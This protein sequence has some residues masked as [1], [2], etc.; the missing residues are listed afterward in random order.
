MISFTIFV[1]DDEQVV[2]EGIS[3]VLRKY[4]HVEAFRSGESAIDSMSS[5]PPDMVLLDVGLPGMSG[6]QA[7]KKIKQR[8]PDM[9]VIMITAFEDVSTVVAAMKLGAYD[10]VVKPVQMD[11]LLVAVRNAFDTVSMRKE[12]Q[13]LHEK[14]LKENLPCFIGE[15]NAIQDVMDI[16]KKAAQSTDT[17]I[18]IQGETGTG[19]ELIAKAIHYRSPHFKGPMIA[20]NC[21]SIPKELIESEL[22]GYEKGAFSGAT[23][24]GKAG[25]VEAADKGTLFL[26]EIGDMSLEAQAKLLRFLEDGEF[27]KVGGTRKRKIS[28]RVVSATNK[29]LLQMIQE[30]RFR[31]DLYHRIS[32]VKIVVPSLNQRRDDI[33]PIAKHFLV[34][35]SQNLNK[36]FTGIAPQAESILKAFEWKGNVRELKNVI[37]KGVLL[38]DGPELILQHLELEMLRQHEDFIKFENG[39]K[40]PPLA[41][42][43]ADFPSVANSI[44]KY[45]FDQALKMTNGNECRAAKL[46]CLSRDRF[47]YRRKK[48]ATVIGQ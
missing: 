3:G 5:T 13:A 31:P 44:E 25:L 9:I 22:F 28:T 17:P 16:V 6:I 10:Y 7:L 4:Y 1:V 21:A 41:P 38:E 43:G 29:D 35:F 12:I 36:N 20:V 47:R 14:C 19:K 15:S 45:Y 46:L 26:D 11:A 42:S 27:Y 30:E 34:E 33:L 48:L 40:L 37:E 18:L 39:T 23:P 24:G 32:V 2:R 8:H